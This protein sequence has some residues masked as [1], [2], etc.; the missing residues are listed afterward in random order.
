M[1]EELSP[2]PA[3]GAQPEFSRVLILLLKGPV[4]QRDDEVLWRRLKQWQPHIQTYVAALRLLLTLDEV[5]GYAFL[6]SMPDPE[7]GPDVS[8]PRLIPRHPLPY[9]ISLLLALL[10]KRLAEADAR[11]STTRLILSQEEIREMLRVFLVDT[12]NEARLVDQ[13]NATLNKVVEMGF[14]RKLP[15]AAASVAAPAS[16]SYEVQRILQSYVD[17]QW[18]SEFDK[19]LQAYRQAAESEGEDA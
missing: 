13:L 15:P 7:D 3:P 5:E 12:S 17:A 4:Y 6:K 14:L 10:R 2:G 11:E 1:S 16:A 8:I 19:Q 9:R 18:L